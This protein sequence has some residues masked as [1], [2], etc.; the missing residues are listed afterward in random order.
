MLGITQILGYGTVYYSFAV[1]AGDI[2]AEFG[3]PV[4]RIFGAFS[5]ALLV[6]GFTAPLAGRLIDRHGAGAV[7][8]AGSLATTVAL[9]ATAWAPGPIAFAAGLIAVEA[10]STLI[11]YDAAFAALVQA[12][13]PHARSR[14]TQLTLIA[15][16]SS[17]IFWPFTTW[18]HGSLGWRE[19]LLVFA[20]LNLLVC[21]PL[22][23]L[24]ARMPP[25]RDEPREAG[26][27]P[28]P[29]WIGEAPMAALGRRVFAL[30]ALGF[31]LSGFLLS[32]VLTQ[33]LPMLTAL[34]LG[35]SAL[36]V[37]TLFGPAQVL[38]RFASIGLGRRRHPLVVTIFGMAMLPLAATILALS[39][40]AAAGAAL[41][42]VLLG[43][44]S[45]LKSIVQG[46][47]PLALFGSAA[48]GTRLGT[49]ALARQFLAAAAPFALAWMM[50]SFGPRAALLAL[51]GVGCL[52]LMAFLEV[53]RIRAR[54]HAAP[55]PEAALHPPT[56]WTG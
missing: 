3:W 36:L 35:T 51:V 20:A 46:T 18:L 48:Y 30:I 28:A 1:L 8:A 34:G 7:M 19:V 26:A 55:G 41:F 16:F 50:E 5:L 43:F 56:G 12:C 14:I 24:I 25:M 52:G 33:M 44:G 4:S 15:G 45:G 17:T 9:A 32:A 39:A 47:L 13:G 27:A 21:L 53:A 54:P 40:P 29:A 6:G 49:L 42:A 23:L 22:H 38:V 2:A 37:S 31:A 11:L 10:A